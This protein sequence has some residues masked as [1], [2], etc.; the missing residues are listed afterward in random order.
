MSNFKIK[1]SDTEPRLGNYIIPDYVKNN[2][3]VDLGSNLCLFEQK[4]N[5]RF[6]EIFY[7]EANYSNFLK[8][9]S[10]IL[11]KGIKNCFGFNYAVSDTS[12]ELIKI[13]SANSMD[14]GSK[15]ILRHPGANVSDYHK[16]ITISLDDIFNLL[17]IERINYLKIDVE[18]A[19][20]AILMNSDLS[21]IDFIAAEIH[22]IMGSDKMTEVRNKILETHEI[23][24]QV[25]AVP[26]KR[27]EETNFKLREI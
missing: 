7:F 11:S 3:A 27:N 18:G 6:N 16:I 25:K 21:R 13:Y 17:E 10:R 5:H 26:D 15:S 14:S 12:G 20:H 8:G 1:T 23:V 19:E 4:Y 24:K 22:N 9:T 2:V